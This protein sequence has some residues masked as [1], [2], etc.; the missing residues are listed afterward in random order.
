MKAVS[1][2]YSFSYWKALSIINNGTFLLGFSGAS[3]QSSISIF[4]IS[5]LYTL[6]NQNKVPGFFFY[7]VDL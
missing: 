7:F 6:Q 1:L 3:R 4:N 2:T 5:F